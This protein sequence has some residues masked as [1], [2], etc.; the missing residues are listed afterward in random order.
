MQHLCTSCHLWWSFLRRRESLLLLVVGGFAFAPLQAL[1]G[2]FVVG[3][4]AVDCSSPTHATLQAAVDAAIDDAAKTPQAPPNQ[5]ILVCPGTY[6]ENVQ[7]AIDTDAM[8]Q[9]VFAFQAVIRGLGPDPSA[10]RI[11]SPVGSQGPIIRVSD[12]AQLILDNLTV[13]GLGTMEPEQ[14]M[15][16]VVGIE[17]RR[18]QE[19]T[20]RSVYV[21][22]IR[23]A[24]GSAQG[25]G[26]AVLGTAAANLD[27]RISPPQVQVEIAESMVSN[28]SRV[29]ILGDGF[30]VVMNVH[31]NNL[32]GPDSPEVWA[33]NGIQLARGAQGEVHNNTVNVATSSIPPAGAGTGILIFC[34]LPTNVHENTVSENDLGISFVDT[35]ASQAIAN[36]VLSNTT[37]I[38]VQVLGFFFSNPEC[39]P[40]DIPP[41]TENV[42]R[43]NTIS[44]STGDGVQFSSFDQDVGVPERNV[45]RGNMIDDQGAFGIHVLQGE[46]N[47]FSDNEITDEVVDETTGV[48]TGGTANT[49]TDNTCLSSNPPD[50]CLAPQNRVV[51]LAQYHTLPHSKVILSSPYMD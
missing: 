44:M 48:G 51:G 39:A 9:P 28:Y 8:G 29:G 31:D 20:I 33:P 13:D 6:V 18:T 45:V 10:V 3:A 21:L 34:A 40:E 35:Q 50:L 27:P 23:N 43:D 5:E 19:T 14:P 12:V 47:T 7:L 1:A 24:D 36:Q 41:T 4:A 30:S 37:G 38:S 32:S 49:W 16:R 2:T 46:R 26:I 17:I 42:F 22:N 25:L 11:E 15:D